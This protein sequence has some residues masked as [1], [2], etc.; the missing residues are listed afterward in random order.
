MS[1]DQY[2]MSSLRAIMA[3]Q[4]ST[5]KGSSHNTDRGS[6]DFHG[7]SSGGL[8][9]FSVWAE[10]NAH[11]SHNAE[12]TFDYLHQHSAHA[13]MADHMSVQATR[14]AHSVSVGS[15]A[16][17]AH[18]E[19]ESEDHFEAATREFSNPN[20]CHAVTYY[21]YRI[22]KCETIKFELVS[23]RRR[24]I[25]PNAPTPVLKNPIV[26]NGGIAVV[27]QDVPATSKARLAIE[28]QAR[29][30]EALKA[31]STAVAVGVASASGA[32][33]TVAQALSAKVRNAALAEVDG[34]LVARGLLDESGVPSK[35][36]KEQIEF[37]REG[38]I[39]T[40]GVLVKGCL[41]DCNT[42]EPELQ[43]KIDLELEHLSLENELL[44]RRIELLDKAQEYR[45]C[46]SDEDEEA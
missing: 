18:K 14:M 24:V 36:I 33:V 26:A 15:V 12:S 5:D 22:N 19:G 8:G 1:E 3:D 6:W 45:C 31:G 35:A 17:R 39:P 11:G 44:K 30:S 16:T 38:V 9:F 10:A 21:F 7:D 28:E 32:T 34:A 43:K 29:T 23:I 40:A 46:P 20:R 41:D 37:E 27:P 2:R 13:S 25:D 4:N 42:C